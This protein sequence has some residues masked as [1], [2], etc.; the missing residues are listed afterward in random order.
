M[1]KWPLQRECNAFYG[2][3]RGKNGAASVEWAQRNLVSVPAPWKL[4][5][6]GK[7]VAGC[8]VHRKCAE[9]LARIFAAIWE[10]CGRSQAEIDRIGMSEF[11]GGYVFRKI[12]GGNSL[13]MHSWG[14]AVDFDPAR[15]GLGNSK[16]AMDRRVIEEF[17]REGWEWGG[18]WRRCDGMHFQAAWTSSRPKRLSAARSASAP[19]GSA[20]ISRDEIAWAQQRLHTLGYHEVGFVDGEMGERTDTAIRAFQRNEKLAATGKLDAKTMAALNE[21]SPR[22]VSGG[23]SSVTKR[24]LRKTYK[25]LA[26]NFQ[27]KVWALLVFIGSAI[28]AAVNG[29]IEFFGEA[30]YRLDSFREFLGDVPAS[31]LFLVAALIALAMWLANDDADNAI[32]DQVRSG[33]AAGWSGDE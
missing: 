16:P 13:S 20:S 10:R 23:R 3:P 4:Y 19:R 5:F 24:E 28:A 18:H 22:K 30:V 1:T 17:E 11:A 12:R 29:I 32:V 33:E 27:A 14:C 21:A 7:P 6:G 8:R 9:S 31:V 2:D 25:P 26:K 15:N